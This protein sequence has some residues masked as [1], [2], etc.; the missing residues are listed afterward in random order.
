V[1]AESYLTHKVGLST[2]FS[3]E[4]GQIQHFRQVH[5]MRFAALV[6]AFLIGLITGLAMSE[7]VRPEI[8]FS[9]DHNFTRRGV[10]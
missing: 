1:R 3:H 2:D 7:P 6:A 8:T 9:T 4:D 5:P 10:D